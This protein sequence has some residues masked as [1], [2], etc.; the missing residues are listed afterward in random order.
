[1]L[2]IRS[3]QLHDV[4]QSIRVRTSTTVARPLLPYINKQRLR[5]QDVLT[6]EG[7]GG[8]EWHFGLAP[9][10]VPGPGK[11][12]DAV[13]EGRGDVFAQVASRRAPAEPLVADGSL[14]L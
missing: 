9:R 10:E 6:V 14:V 8:G 13:I 11:T 3:P 4:A 1:M 7:S 12:P 5:P 2:R